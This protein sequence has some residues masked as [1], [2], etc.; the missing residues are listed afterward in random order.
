MYTASPSKP[1]FDGWH[2]G[3]YSEWAQL[4]DRMAVALLFYLMSFAWTDRF[5]M[6]VVAVFFLM[7]A[8]CWLCEVYTQ[9]YWNFTFD[10]EASEMLDLHYRLD[11]LRV[12][13]SALLVCFLSGDLAFLITASIHFNNHKCASNITYFSLSVFVALATFTRFIAAVSSTTPTQLAT[14]HRPIA[15]GHAE[16]AKAAALAS[17]S[18]RTQR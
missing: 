13:L 14:S 7:H 3:Y 9:S 10:Y 4:G 11:E 8:V 1:S 15:K 17:A 6:S 2:T 12:Y 5:P 16:A 18:S